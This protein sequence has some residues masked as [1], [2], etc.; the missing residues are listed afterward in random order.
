MSWAL[1]TIVMCATIAVFAT[2]TLDG[3][4]FGFPKL[5]RVVEELHG[6]YRREDDGSAYNDDGEICTLNSEEFTRRLEALRCNE[7]Y[8]QAVREEIERSN[9]VSEVYD[10]ETN[11]YDESDI[12]VVTDERDD[13]NVRCSDGCA[14]NQYRYLYCKYIGEETSL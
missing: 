14:T 9:C 4:T 10:P 1:S 13:V 7:E 8:M 2:G 6:N 12:C 5:D 3:K 11:G